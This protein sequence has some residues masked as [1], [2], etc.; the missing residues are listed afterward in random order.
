MKVYAAAVVDAVGD[1]RAVDVGTTLDGNRGIRSVYDVIGGGSSRNFDRSRSCVV[2]Q[3]IPRDTVLFMT[4]L[5]VMLMTSP[6]QEVPVTLTTTCAVT[7]VA[8]SVELPA[9]LRQLM[10]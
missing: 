9:M 5:P 6:P 3:K 7:G 4:E 1:H 10:L 2:E 8:C